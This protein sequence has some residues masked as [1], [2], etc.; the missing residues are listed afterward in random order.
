[1][2][3]T[4]A[5]VNSADLRK[6]EIRCV[7]LHHP[8]A[9]KHAFQYVDWQ[10]DGNDIVAVSRTAWDDDAGGA[11]NFHDANFMTFHRVRNFRKL[12]MRGSAISLEKLQ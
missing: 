7:L 3:N 9:D 4:L 11:H 5:L 10:F 6:W 12:T 1:V 2:R 8:D